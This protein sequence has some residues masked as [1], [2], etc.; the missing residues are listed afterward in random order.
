M[1]R[2]LQTCTPLAIEQDLF[3]YTNPRTHQSQS[4]VTHGKPIQGREP[5]MRDYFF[6]RI[7]PLMEAALKEGDHGNWPLITLNLDFK[8]DESAHHAEVWKLLKQYEPWISSAE[9]TSDKQM[10]MP[11]RIR[12]LLVLTGEADSHEGSGTGQICV[13]SSRPMSRGGSKRCDADAWPSC[14]AV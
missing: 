4:L 10:V 13:T 11:L 12:P 9:R 6:E 5:T 3:W 8:S 2:A 1:E 7:R 14:A